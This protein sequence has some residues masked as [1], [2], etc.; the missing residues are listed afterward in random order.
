MK[1][2]WMIYRLQN[3]LGRN[4]AGGIEEYI[5][6]NDVIKALKISRSVLARWLANPYFRRAQVA[7]TYEGSSRWYWN[8]EKLVTWVIAAL[9][10]DVKETRYK[11]S[12]PPVREGDTPREI[13]GFIEDHKN[14]AGETSERTPLYALA[15]ERLDM[16]TDYV[17]PS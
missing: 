12:N 11:K 16:P 1:K 8:T 17:F 5:S 9:K 13:S 2:G 14:P 6:T 3:V 10:L 4:A 15:R 7:I